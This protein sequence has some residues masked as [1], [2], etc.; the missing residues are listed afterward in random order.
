MAQK[1]QVSLLIKLSTSLRVE[2]H[3]LLSSAW[4]RVPNEQCDLNS[5]DIQ[6]PL[7]WPTFLQRR[8]LALEGEGFAHPYPRPWALPR[9]KYLKV[10][11][12]ISLR[13][14]GWVMVLSRCRRSGWLK[15]RSP[16]TL[17][18]MSPFSSKTSVPKASTMR[19]WAGYPG[20]TTGTRGGGRVTLQSL[21]G[22]PEDPSG[23]R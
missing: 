2:G 16:R 1:P 18:L 14:S 7:R 3:L 12:I 6:L 19:R 15:I 17:R 4:G 8:A 5:W 10:S 22:R 11:F 20:W 21:R 9:R 23:G 13:I